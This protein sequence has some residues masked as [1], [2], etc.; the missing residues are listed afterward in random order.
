V[1]VPY[2]HWPGGQ[3]VFQRTCRPVS[4]KTGKV[5]EKVT[6][7]ITSLARQR[8]QAYQLEQFY[9]GHWTIENQSHY[10][11][12]E[13]LREDRGQIHKGHAPQALAA[14]RNGLLMTLRHQGWTDIADALRYYAA[15][16][17]KAFTFLAGNAT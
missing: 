3:Q 17:T 11:R 1:L 4:N 8:A 14:L 6:Y 13:T 5:S 10:V 2:L 9:R 7:G 12:D 15:S 16:V